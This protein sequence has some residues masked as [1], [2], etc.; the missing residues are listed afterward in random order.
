MSE[1]SKAV[2]AFVI[3]CV[4]GALSWGLWPSAVFD[5]SLSGITLRAIGSA[6]LSILVAC[7]GIGWAF[8]V[9]TESE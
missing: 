1:S 4:C 8:H 9:A 5:T 7:K 6:F 2:T 3:L